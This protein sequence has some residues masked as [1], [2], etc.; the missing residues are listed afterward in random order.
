M[1]PRSFDNVARQHQRIVLNTVVGM[2]ILTCNAGYLLGYQN[3]LWGYV[4]PPVGSVLGDSETERQKLAQ[5]VSVIDSEQPDVVSLLEVDQGSHRTATAGQYRTLINSL[6]ERELP[7]E[8]TVANKYCF[9]TAVF[10]LARKRDALS[11][12][13]AD[14]NALSHRWQKTTGH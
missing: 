3:V 4:P 9:V 1:G 7:Y 5:L 12:G 10:W 8:G 2:K 14:A 13:P 6:H 11:K